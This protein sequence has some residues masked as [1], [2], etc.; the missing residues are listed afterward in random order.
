MGD[1]T[2]L[3]YDVLTQGAGAMN[4]A[5]AL[6]GAIDPRIPVNSNWLVTGV[7]T[8]TTID[9]Q[10]IVWGDLASCN[11]VWGDVFKIQ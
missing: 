1:A 2:G 5:G 4:R 7:T 6:A 9:G 11:I 8:N 10:N 3:R